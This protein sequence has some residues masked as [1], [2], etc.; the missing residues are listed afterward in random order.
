MEAVQ[1]D[2][3]VQAGGYTPGAPLLVPVACRQSIPAGGTVLEAPS[4]DSSC[5]NVAILTTQGGG[6]KGC[7]PS[8]LAQGQAGVSGGNSEPRELRGFP[9]LVGGATWGTW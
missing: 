5:R 4:R 9:A 2:N 1:V 7:A 6:S 3:H 8:L